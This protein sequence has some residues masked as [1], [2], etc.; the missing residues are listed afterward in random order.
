MKIITHN[1]FG[2]LDFNIQAADVI[3]EKEMEGFEILLWNDSNVEIAEASLDKCAKFIENYQS[4]IQEGREA[5][6]DYLENDGN[7]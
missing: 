4:K 1:Y 3:L 5:L 6:R 7:I 2:K